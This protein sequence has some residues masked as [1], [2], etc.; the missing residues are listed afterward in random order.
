MVRLQINGDGWLD[1]STVSLIYSLRNNSG[2]PNQLLRTISG[3]WSF[4][5]R[6]RCMYQGAIVDDIDNCRTHEMMSI[7]TSQRNRDKDTVEG[8]G[9][10]WDSDIDYP[11]ETGFRGGRANA[12]ATLDGTFT[13]TLA[14]GGVASGGAN[15][16]S[17]KPLLGLCGQ[18]KYIPLMWG[19]LVLEFEI[20]GNAEDAIISP[21]PSR[22]FLPTDT[23]VSWQIEDVRC[24]GDVVT[25]DSALQN[26]YVEHVLSGKSR[27]INYNTHTTMQQTVRRE[28][29][30]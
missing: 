15:T 24:V 1:P 27:P 17:F 7:L 3:P 6:V 5:R 10:C 25:L 12:T 8:F 2:S 22:E 19:G 21:A 18:S 13:Q 20:V 14:Y 9:W 16:V 28:Y 11:A 30:F 4:F 29:I 23:S 26:S